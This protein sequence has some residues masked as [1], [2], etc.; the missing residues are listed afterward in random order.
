MSSALGAKHRV[1]IGPLV[2]APE[3]YRLFL[4]LGHGGTTALATSPLVL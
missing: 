1:N 4:S 3:A 2:L